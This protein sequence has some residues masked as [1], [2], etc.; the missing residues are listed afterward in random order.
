VAIIVSV[1]TAMIPSTVSWLRNHCR[2]S[3]KDGDFLNMA[4]TPLSFGSDVMQQHRT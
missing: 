3:V 1:N 4:L 2:T